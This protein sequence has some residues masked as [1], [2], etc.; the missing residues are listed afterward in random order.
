MKNNKNPLSWMLRLALVA[1]VCVGCGLVEII[2]EDGDVSD[3][4][5]ITSGNGDERFVESERCDSTWYPAATCG[6]KNCVNRRTDLAKGESTCLD[7]Y[8]IT[9]NDRRLG[10]TEGCEDL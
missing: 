7:E 4:E 8:V 10:G 5:E 9:T 3:D 6:Y 2:V 1:S